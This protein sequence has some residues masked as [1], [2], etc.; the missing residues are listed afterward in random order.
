MRRLIRPIF[1]GLQ[2]A[3]GHLFGFDKRKYRRFEMG[4]LKGTVKYENGSPAADAVVTVSQNNAVKGQDTT[5]ADGSYTIGRLDSGSFQVAVEKDEEERFK[6]NVDV[7][8][9]VST[10]DIS[11]PP[12]AAAAGAGSATGGA[13]TGAADSAPT[14]ATASTGSG[15]S[16]SSSSGAS[17]GGTGSGD[18]SGTGSSTGAGGSSTSGG[19]GSSGSTGS[20]ASGS[21][22]PSGTGSTTGGC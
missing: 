20:G 7:S 16:G 1:V 6:G 15:P 10:F 5:G 4:R 2:E 13:S 12:K 18:P 14:G 11:L 8:G 3:F 21:G 19:T 9:T 22:D 17:T